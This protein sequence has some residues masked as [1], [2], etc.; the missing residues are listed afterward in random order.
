M[1]AATL[2]TIAALA[3]FSPRGARGA[4]RDPGAAAH[5]LEPGPRGG[6]S[7]VLLAAAGRLAGPFLYVAG[8]GDVVTGV[9]A[10]PVAW[11][12]MGQ[13]SKDNCVIAGWN[14]FGALDSSR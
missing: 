13:S 11:L 9:L 6:V 2:A 3:F 7:F 1:F 4:A 5:R 14:A 8:W 10:N 12:G